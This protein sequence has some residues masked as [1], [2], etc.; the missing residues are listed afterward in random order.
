MQLP[1]IYLLILQQPLAGIMCRCP[2]CFRP[3]VSAV[4]VKIEQI[5]KNSHIFTCH[6]LNTNYLY[7]PLRI[8]IRI[9]FQWNAKI[10]TPSIGPVIEDIR[11]YHSPE[12]RLAPVLQ[13]F[14]NVPYHILVA[15]LTLMALLALLRAIRVRLATSIWYGTLMKNCFKDWSQLTREVGLE[16]QSMQFQKSK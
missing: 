14:I 2:V 4:K 5:D 1:A 10:D 3:G 7:L 15:S 9:V 8:I 11:P 12:N 6:L 16:T 13:F